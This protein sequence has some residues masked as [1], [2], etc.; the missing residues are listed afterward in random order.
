MAGERAVL[1][2]EVITERLDIAPELR[3]LC[4]ITIDSIELEIKGH[5]KYPNKAKKL[6]NTSNSPCSC[7]G[8]PLY[9][10][11]SL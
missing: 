5:T 2:L 4:M 3:E 1:M 6:D 8:V 7:A 9:V 11:V 10:D